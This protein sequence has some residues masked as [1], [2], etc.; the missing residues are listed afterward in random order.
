MN[1]VEINPDFKFKFET[2]K[3]LFN[4][5]MSGYIE[6]CDV[7]RICIKYVGSKGSVDYPLKSREDYIKAIESYNNREDVEVLEVYQDKWFYDRND[8]L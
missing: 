6:L 4:A 7:V 3:E 1:K 5:Q 2:E 8:Y